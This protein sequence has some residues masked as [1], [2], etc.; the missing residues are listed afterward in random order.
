MAPPKGRVK[1]VAVALAEELSGS[2]EEVEV[3]SKKAKSPKAAKSPVS[4]G[5][6]APVPAKR[7]RGRPLKGAKKANKTKVAYVPTG[8]PR[9]RPKTK[10]SD[11]EEEPKP[12]KRKVDDDSDEAEP[13][14][15]G[16]PKKEVPVDDEE[17][18]EEEEEEEKAPP[19]AKRGRKAG[20]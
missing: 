15:K 12:S 20:K 4:N 5:E 1:T 7:G 17:D 18:D 3:S 2:E 9:G 8:L 6:D 16:R 10:V 13:K 11:D 14:S 19:P